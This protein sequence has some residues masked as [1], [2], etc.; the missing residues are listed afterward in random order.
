M[1]QVHAVDAKEARTGLMS[2][3]V[4]VSRFAGDLGEE[5]TD[6]KEFSLPAEPEK[7]L[8]SINEPAALGA[9]LLR[10]LAS[11]LRLV[12]K[13][14]PI[15]KLLV[16]S[17]VPNEGKTLISANL[18]I[19]L[20]LHQKS[21]LL[22]DGDLRSSS[23]S[24]QFDIVDDSLESNWRQQDLYHLPSLRKARGLAL[25]VI[26]AGKPIDQ[27]SKILQSGQFGDALVAIEPDFDWI[28]IDSPPLVPFGDAE[29]LAS[30]A[31][32]VV[33]V[34]RKGVTPKNS[35]RDALKSFDKSKIIA[36]ILNCADVSS[37]KYYREY[38]C[39]LERALPPP[40]AVDRSHPGS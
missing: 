33:L 2:E 37:H 38:Y 21:V 28:V 20:A 11:R 31:D 26:P 12:Q 22:I 8:V 13:R 4:E 5:P 9:E 36:T 24:R 10:T 32:A 40:N 34:T 6:P 35:L 27:P 3:G 19:T 39:H 23:L 18:A 30:L 7:R 14:H 29:F 17:A 1:G 25:W 16:T 15:R